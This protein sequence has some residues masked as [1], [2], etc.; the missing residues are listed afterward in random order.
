MLGVTKEDIIR[1]T[2][3]YLRG[4]LEKGLTSKVIFGVDAV[5]KKLLRESGWIVDKPI[6]LL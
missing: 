2:N 3:Q 1:V 5:N 4:P 6:D